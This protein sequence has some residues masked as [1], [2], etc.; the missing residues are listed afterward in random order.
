MSKKTL[1][2]KAKALKQG[3]KLK[4]ECI[5]RVVGKELLNAPTIKGEVFILKVLGE[6]GPFKGQIINMFAHEAEELDTYIRP[7]WLQRVIMKIWESYVWD[8]SFAKP[9]HNLLTR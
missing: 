4:M 9:P 5:V 8:K 1:K 7:R 6:T 3:T 2:K